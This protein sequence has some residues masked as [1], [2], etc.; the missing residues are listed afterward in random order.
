MSTGPMAGRTCRRSLAGTVSSLP[1]A[2][3]CLPGRA[4][5]T[6]RFV[7]RGT[8]ALDAS[9]VSFRFVSLVPEPVTSNFQN[10]AWRGR[11]LLESDIVVG[12]PH[13]RPL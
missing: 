3:S 2:L 12:R 10:H 11:R 5:I 4:D 6:K 13:E 9:F 8:T 1:Y 7:T